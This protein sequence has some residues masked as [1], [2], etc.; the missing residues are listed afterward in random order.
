MG[1]AAVGGVMGKIFFLL[2]FN[3]HSFAIL[4]KRGPKAPSRAHGVL[5]AERVPSPPQELER[6]A[7]S[8]LNF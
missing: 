3:C 5:A 1:G 8:T 6:R 7:R 2:K 4:M